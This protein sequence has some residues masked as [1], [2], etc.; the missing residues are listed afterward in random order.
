LSGRASRENSKDAWEST[1]IPVKQFPADAEQTKALRSLIG[2]LSQAA[3]RKAGPHHEVLLQ[4]WKLTP[5]NGS[6]L[7]S[8]HMAQ[9]SP[10]LGLG[11][12]PNRKPPQSWTE[13]SF[14]D[15]A[16]ATFR[17]AE[18]ELPSHRLLRLNCKPKIRHEA[19]H[20]MRGLGTLVECFSRE[21]FEVLQTRGKELYLPSISTRRFQHEDFY[22][23]LLDRQSLAAARNSGELARWL[24]GIDLYVRE[25]PEDTG[26]L[27]VSRAPLGPIVE[28]AQRLLQEA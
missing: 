3:V 22:L 15:A 8:D 7:L 24:C 12:W 2:A 10:Q 11:V 5:A 6:N 9:W 17:A 4:A 1:L 28:V 27:I 16:A 20:T 26:V 14:V 25:S 23:P 13:T 21:S 19:A 18:P